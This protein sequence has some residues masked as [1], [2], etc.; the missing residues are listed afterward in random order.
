M[1]PHEA[2]ELGRQALIITLLVCAPILA[3]GL[4]VGLIVGLLQAITQVQD[5]TVAFVPK[6]L[7][8]IG[9]L[10]LSMPWLLTRLVDF[11]RELLMNIPGTL[12]G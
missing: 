6:L 8:M 1:Q 9:A 3:A 4:I 10:A 11:T 2:I 5:Q 12:G 7:A